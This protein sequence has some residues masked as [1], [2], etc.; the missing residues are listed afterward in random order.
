M[1]YV[2]YI[3]LCHE[4]TWT[5]KNENQIASGALIPLEL[6][7]VPSG[8]IMRKQIP[9]DAT[10]QIVDFSKQHPTERL[11][12]IR[13]GLSVSSLSFLLFY[14]LPFIFLNMLTDYFSFL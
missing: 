11:A 7:E 9:P 4:R 3:P 6:C 14:A 1:R 2:D 13:T 10:A 5:D 8:H 12:S